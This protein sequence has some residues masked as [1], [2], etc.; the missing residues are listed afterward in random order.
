MNG[1]LAAA[2]LL[3]AGGCAFHEAMSGKFLA[4]LAASDLPGRL[5]WL[6]DLC[7]HFV[8]LIFAV[9]AAGFVA[10]AFG[11]LQGDAT[12]FAGVLAGAI[13]I[14]CGVGAVRAGLPPWR[15]PASYVLGGAAVLAFVA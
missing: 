2:A 14:L 13:A 1:A 8:G 9:L 10:G 6:L 11:W 3:C 4:P 12:R 7:W 15:H 5:K